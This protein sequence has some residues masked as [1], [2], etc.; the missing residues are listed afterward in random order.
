MTE[1]PEPGLGRI[2]WRTYGPDDP[3]TI[4]ERLGDTEEAVGWVDDWTGHGRTYQYRAPFGR[5]LH[6]VF[7]DVDLYQAPSEKQDTGLLMRPRNTVVGV[8]VPDTST[9]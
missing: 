2:G 8:L 4:A 9:T 7:W 1:A 5:H 3:E 6:E